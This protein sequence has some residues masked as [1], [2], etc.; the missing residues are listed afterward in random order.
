MNLGN[1]YK[2]TN[3]PRRATVS[4]YGRKPDPLEYHKTKYKADIK[5]L[6]KKDLVR[7]TRYSVKTK[8]SI[9][10]EVEKN[11]F[12]RMAFDYGDTVGEMPFFLGYETDCTCGVEAVTHI[13]PL[14]PQ[15]SWRQKI[16]NLM[17][18][19]EKIIDD[20]YSPSDLRC[21]G[22]ITIG[23]DNMS[24][25]DIYEGM[26]SNIGIIYAL[27]RK[28][29]TNRNCRYVLNGI[30]S[31]Y[32]QEAPIHNG[33]DSK[34]SPVKLRGNGSIEFRLV[35]RF[36]SVKQMKDRY[37]LFYEVVDHSFNTPNARYSTLIKRLKPILMSM[38]DND[39]SKV[40]EIIALS[41]DFR[42]YLMTKG[43]TIP[44]SIAQW[45]DPCGENAIMNREWRANQR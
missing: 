28:R 39:M 30:F 23:V 14:L 6:K 43:M 45:V 32:Q 27:F 22:H 20:N 13:H 4:R 25:L 37:K 34:Y 33:Y 29:L 38:Y 41:Y 42:R 35:S 8:F 18:D 44:Q 36:Q 31:S 1:I 15:S 24:A 19:A 12:N 2:K 7:D 11:N 17:E 5:G 3:N 21:G 26:R 9:G 16:F 10:M 40:E